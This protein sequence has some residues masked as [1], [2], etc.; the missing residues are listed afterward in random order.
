MKSTP[1]AAGPS[2]NAPKISAN[3]PVRLFLWVV[4]GGR[5]ERR[6][7]NKYLLGNQAIGDHTLYPLG[8]VAHN[9]P[10]SARGPRSGDELAIER[11]NDIENLLL[12]CPMCHKTVDEALKTGEFTV[13]QLRDQKREHEA[14]I[15]RLTEIAATHES[16]VVRLVGTIHG[17]AV[18]IAA[19][20]I[21][22]AVVHQTTR[23]PRYRG[24]PHEVDIDLRRLP[25][26]NDSAYW[27][28]GRRI[29]DDQV[30]NLLRPRI[31]AEPPPHVSVFALARIP[32][33]IYLGAR[34]GDKIPTEVFQKQRTAGQL[35][36][37]VAGPTVLFEHRV[38]RN[39]GTKWVMILAVSGELSVDL[40]PAELRDHSVVELRPTN[41]EPGREICTSRQTFEA[42]RATYGRALRW[43][44]AAGAEEIAVVPAVPVSIA[45]ACGR[46]RLPA[47]TP[48]LVVYDRI[49]GAYVPTITI[50]G[51]L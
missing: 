39:A 17:S 28:T 46:E 8:E 31:G 25:E 35:W 9:V 22:H 20:D 48:P 11:R 19:D 21:R 27:E 50:T 34:L 42:F 10:R 37:W 12:L 41:A 5:C 30:E 7:C 33:L 47:V 18:E 4:A 51:S 13:D 6:G 49:G 29:I 15:Y 26:G 44:E 3:D 40:L 43:L 45:V 24:S 23:F 32:F 16:L 36:S 38:V 1:P 2:P 14:R